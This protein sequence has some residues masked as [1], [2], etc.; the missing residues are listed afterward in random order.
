MA[1]AAVVVLVRKRCG[2]TGASIYLCFRVVANSISLASPQAA[3][4][5]HFVAPPFPTKSLILRGAPSASRILL[6]KNP[7][8]VL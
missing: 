4:L 6:L 7:A 2:G 3:K 5:T 8:F 1:G